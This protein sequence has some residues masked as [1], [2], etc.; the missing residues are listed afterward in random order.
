MKFTFFSS[1]LILMSCYTFSQTNQVESLH[2]IKVG[3]LSMAYAYEKALAQ[4]STINFEVDLQGRHG[5]YSTEG[6]H[7]WLIPGI[8]VEPR[9]YYNFQRRVN[10]GKKTINNSANY[11]SLSTDYN[12]RKNSYG[13]M[14]SSITIIPKWGFRRT[15]GEKFLFEFAGGLGLS[16]GFGL[17]SSRLRTLQL[18]GEIDFKIGYRF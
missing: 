11:F 9:Y 18:G 6:K 3:Y 16:G 8:R 17:D 12:I 14:V 10:K 4:K 1:V 5:I 13:N 2:S 7:W 15:I